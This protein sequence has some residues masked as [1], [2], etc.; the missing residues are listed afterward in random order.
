MRSSNNSK[1]GFVIISALAYLSI[2]YLFPR[3]EFYF[4]IV[5]FSVVFTGYYFS[6]KEQWFTSDKEVITIAML[7]RILFLFSVPT[8]SDDFYRYLWDG[9]L[10]VDGIN[11][12]DY[13]PFELI[14][15]G[16]YTSDILF[17]KMNSPLFYSVYPPTNQFFFT[18][19]AW[20]GQGDW[21]MMLLVFKI[22]ILVLEFGTLIL[23]NKISSFLDK[24]FVPLLI[25]GFN[26]LVIV[27][28]SGNVHS[29]VI[30]LFFIA[31]FVYTILQN[32]V[33]GSAISL[34]LAVCSKLIPVLL[35]PLL[36]S[37]I[38]WK[39]T[40]YFGVTTGAVCLLLFGFVYNETFL[41]HIY[42]SL[43]LYFKWFEFNGLVYLGVKYIDGYWI[44]GFKV[45]MKF[46]SL[47]LLL[48]IYMKAIRDIEGIFKE[49]ILLF[50]VYFMFSSTV[51]P[52][53]IAALVFYAAFTELKY[54]LIWT[55][56]LPLSY[57]AYRIDP[58]DQSL[59]LMIVEYTIVW[60]VLIKE[61]IQNGSTQE[62][63]HIQK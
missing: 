28:F 20:L 41:S 53:Y 18:F 46:V 23:I 12:F 25:Y 37:K 22:I 58:N 34:A 38:G 42:E 6:I 24:G 30:M 63:S 60:G 7:F 54:T 39:K 50:T 61:L 17:E 43:Q 33:M 44:S 8:L 19:S 10:V 9:Q 51:H 29:E 59:V 5:S 62:Q 26:P 47:G 36:I 1:Y 2:A 15:Q 16:V 55:L 13:K 27:E 32:K 21:Q 45:M 40:F 11:P 3:T 14:E 57:F 4:L 48:F 35:L 31:L 52:W 49:A 56:V